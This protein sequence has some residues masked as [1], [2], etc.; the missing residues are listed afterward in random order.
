MIQENLI[1]L[2]GKENGFQSRDDPDV[3]IIKQ[4]L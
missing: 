1:I 2:K 3:E 4:G